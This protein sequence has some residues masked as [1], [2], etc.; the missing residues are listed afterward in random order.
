M[1]GSER[2]TRWALRRCELQCRC[3]ELVSVADPR[4]DTAVRAERCCD[5]VQRRE[6]SVRPRADRRPSERWIRAL[7]LGVLTT[8]VLVRIRR[9][10]EPDRRYRLGPSSVGAAAPVVEFGV[11]ETGE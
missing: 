3:A 2:R 6:P 11:V 7:D 4:H 9:G 10:N 1:G 5:T 8:G